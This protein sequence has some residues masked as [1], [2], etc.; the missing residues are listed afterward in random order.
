MTGARTSAR[1]RG[2][3]EQRTL[4]RREDSAK[5][6]WYSS[7]E[8]VQVLASAYVIGVMA[9][10]VWC[11]TCHPQHVYAALV[12]V[13]ALTAGTMVI[14]RIIRAKKRIAR[15]RL[16]WSD[17][18][19]VGQ[20]LEALRARGYRVYHDVRD[21]DNSVDHVVIGPAGVYVIVTQAMGE[22]PEADAAITYDGQRI[23]VNDAE[24]E[25]DPLPR[26]R[27]RR[28]AI[29]RILAIGAARRPPLRPVVLF[30]GWWIVRQT[31]SAEIWVLHPSS[32][33]GLLDREPERLS[34]ADIALFSNVLESHIQSRA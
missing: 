27:A 5:E 4:A 17:E 22:P 6:P 25:H 33:P 16:G 9:F 24:L 21:G 28:D 15:L 11:S 34:T 8:A 18:I 12:T 13:I 19:S 3:L 23:L 1:T 2:P 7:W 30:A 29:G 26:V 31:R 32:F 14:S 10:F 20:D